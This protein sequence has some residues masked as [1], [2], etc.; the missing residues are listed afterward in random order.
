MKHFLCCLLLLTAYHLQ[1]QVSDVVFVGSAT[2]G[3]GQSFTYKLQLT[4]SDGVLNGYSITDVMGPDETK[5][6]IKGTLD[7]DK[8]RI[9]FRETKIVYSKGKPQKN[10]DL[11]ICYMQASL[12][13]ST[14]K[15]ATIL[16]GTFKGVKEDGVTECAKGS[17]VLISAKDLMAKLMKANATKDT[18]VEKTILP[19]KKEVPITS[20]EVAKILPGT[21][22][23]VTCL[24][25]IAKLEI[26]DAKTIDG[27][28]ISILHNGRILL[29]HYT[30]TGDH[31]A[32]NVH[33][34][35]NQSDTLKVIAQ[36]EGTEPLNTARIKIVSAG[37]TQHIDASTTIDK[38]IWIILKRK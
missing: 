17:L 38:P 13:I 29:D 28:V 31:K 19:Q 27:D 16:K 36:N 35:P 23:E 11:Y 1:A 14:K 10:Q 20:A 3:D 22:K 12:K 18:S 37:E 8:K 25:E 5:A 33:L 7:V 4:D 30:L 32:I 2:T 34:A 9:K 6:L 15:G 24:G 21:A 26:W